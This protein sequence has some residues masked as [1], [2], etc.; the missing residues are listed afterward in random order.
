M[1]T[2]PLPCASLSKALLTPHLFSHRL[3]PASAPPHGV[4]VNECLLPTD[5]LPLTGGPSTTALNIL[6]L[7]VRNVSEYRLL[8]YGGK[9]ACP[10]TSWEVA[11][12][13]H[14]RVC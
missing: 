11:E 13:G 5:S 7:T 14:E 1:R 6:Q 2:K 12:P 10:G 4:W 3:S 8:S 9:G